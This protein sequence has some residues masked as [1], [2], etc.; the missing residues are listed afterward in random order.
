MAACA[1][2]SLLCRRGSGGL[3]DLESVAVSY[4]RCL[5]TKDSDSSSEP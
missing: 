1:E 4:V 2:S 5:G 3:T